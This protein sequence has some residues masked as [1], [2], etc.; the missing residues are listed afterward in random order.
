MPAL[1]ACL[2]SRQWG[3][4]DFVL[5]IVC[6]LPN[7]IVTTFGV[8]G[9]SCRSSKLSARDASGE[10]SRVLRKNS[11]AYCGI[12]NN[13]HWQPDITFDEDRRRTRKDFPPANLA[14]VRHI[15][16]NMLK[17]DTSILSLK[18]KRLK[19]SVNPGFRARLLAC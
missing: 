10:T 15:V 12:E 3:R 7:E 18:R 8:I 11:G 2:A 19:A 4:L 5:A 17:R 16:L 6:R 1:G 14:I 13:P 9:W